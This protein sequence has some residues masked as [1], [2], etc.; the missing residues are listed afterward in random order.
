[1]NRIL[2]KAGQPLSL[3]WLASA[4]MVIANVMLILARLF[5]LAWIVPVA[6]LLIVFFAVALDYVLYFIVLATPLALNMGDVI[7]GLSVS[8]PTEPLLAALLLI[9][10]IKLLMGYVPDQRVFTHPIVFAVMIYLSWMLFTSVTS[11]YPLISFK[12]FTARLWFIVPMLFMG[13]PLFK[14]IRKIRLF[15][16]LYVSTM[17]L[18]IAYTI[19]N[20][21][22]SGFTEKAANLS[23]SPFYSDHTAYAVMLAF[24]TPA[25]VG[26][27]L[28]KIY[29]LRLRMLALAI[30]ALFVTGIIL[31]YCRAAWISLG[32][33][34][35][36]LLLIVFRIR[37]RWILG[38]MVITVGLFYLFQ[39]QIVDRLEKNK[40]ESSANYTEH[41]E[42][43][44]NVSTD[45]S[46]LER[47]NRW[48]CAIRLFHEHP[49]L[50]WGPGT[51][52]FVYG[53]FQLDSEKTI[54]S[55]NEGNRG[56]AHSEYL[57]PLSESG[58]PGL[59]T[60]LLLFSTVTYTG[61]R[62]YQRVGNSEVRLLS[63]VTLLGFISYFAHGLM[64]NFLDTDKSSVPFWGFAAIIVAIDLYHTQ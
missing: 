20:H 27:S 48:K 16:W 4:F 58:W 56:N 22:G 11:Q 3:F 1:M 51:Y 41:V 62:L 23:P 50:G 15:Y 37:F 59:L 45:A 2:Q 33:S 17:C 5:W 26:F 52:Q 32:V 40:Q 30:L 55:T 6:I 61:I 53:P 12:Y 46:N 49:T 24:F 38:V 25:L 10:V 60:I 8:I 63:M 31:S 29:P 34:L 57:G 35:I 43:M 13:T 47:I 64:N 7:P 42:S 14:D 36:V 39:Q 28:S 54:I 44:L 19:Y 18:V 21:A 9:F